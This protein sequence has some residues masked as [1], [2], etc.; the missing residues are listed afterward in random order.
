MSKLK[1]F[2]GWLPREITDKFAASKFG[3]FLDKKF[4][5]IIRK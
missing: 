4:F 5:K 3:E 1:G 2:R